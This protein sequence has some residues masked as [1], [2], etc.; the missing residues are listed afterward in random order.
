MARPD[1]YYTCTK[2]R[3]IGLDSEPGPLSRGCSRS[4]AD[5]EQEEQLSM[6]HL[7]LIMLVSC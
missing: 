1:S 5:T 7:I 2:D 4:I 3:A 6:K